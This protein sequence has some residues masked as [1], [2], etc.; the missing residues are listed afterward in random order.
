MT[1]ARINFTIYQGTTFEKVF[2]FDDDFDLTGY[3][4][5]LIAKLEKS[6][7]TT[8]ITSV[9]G[10]PNCTLTISI[11]EGTITWDMTD[12]ETAALDFEVC[13]WQ[14]ELTIA[15]D[16]RRYFYGKLFLDKEL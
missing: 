5:V 6:S 14:M 4:A 8:L 11:G 10:S 12:E 13:E 16:T 7:T 2:K 15:G 9:A 3:T 1:P